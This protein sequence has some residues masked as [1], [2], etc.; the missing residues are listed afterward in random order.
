[1]DIAPAISGK[2]EP[3]ENALYAPRE[4]VGNLRLTAAP[5]AVLPCFPKP[6]HQ[7]NCRGYS[8]ISSPVTSGVAVS[9][10]GKWNMFGNVGAL[11]DETLAAATAKAMLSEYLTT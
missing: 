2:V 7:Q 10:A 11:A 3:Q 5:P 9:R 6:K 8:Q 1:M 4:M